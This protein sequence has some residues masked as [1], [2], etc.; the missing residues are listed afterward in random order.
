[1]EL[2]KNGKIT[3]KLGVKDF[4]WI[5]HFKDHGD[6]EFA[7]GASL[8]SKLLKNMGVVEKTENIRPISFV[9]LMKYNP[10]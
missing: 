8:D 5:N 1:V 6:L 7:M 2:V 10:K 9:N 4:V 3:Y